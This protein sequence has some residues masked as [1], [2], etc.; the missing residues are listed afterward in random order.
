VLSAV[1][2]AVYLAPRA[3]RVAALFETEG[4]TSSEARRLMDRMFVVSRLELLSFAIVV[5]L[6][7]FKPDV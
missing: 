3:R 7:T 6:M 5:A 4:P 2:G 1:A